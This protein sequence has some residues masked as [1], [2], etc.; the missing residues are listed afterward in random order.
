MSY[1]TIQDK[2]GNPKEFKYKSTFSWE[3]AKITDRRND[4]ETLMNSDFSQEREKSLKE[5]IKKLELE[6]E[7]LRK[8]K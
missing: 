4:M 8:R 3:L 6:N 5:R 7:A 1:I 2:D